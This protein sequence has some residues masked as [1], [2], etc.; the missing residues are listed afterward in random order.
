MFRFRIKADCIDEPKYNQV[1]GKIIDLRRNFILSK[2][3][4]Y[5]LLQGE[6]LKLKW[7]KH[8]W[9]I[10]ASYNDEYEKY[11][12]IKKQNINLL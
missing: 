3:E 2:D 1:Y 12:E 5:R 11:K 10:S 7:I 8:E 4:L 9:I 6:D